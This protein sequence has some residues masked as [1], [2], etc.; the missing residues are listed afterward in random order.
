VSSIRVLDGSIYYYDLAGV[1][2]VAEGDTKGAGA[3][4]LLAGAFWLYVNDSEVAT[5][6][7]H[8]GDS[9]GDVVLFQA[10][11]GSPVRQPAT[12][13]SV[14]G[15]YRYAG[16]QSKLFGSTS[17]RP[18]SY[19]SHDIATGQEQN[20]E[21]QLQVPDD[22]DLLATA[23]AL[24]VNS[25]GYEATDKTDLYRIDTRGGDPVAIDTGI[26]VRF[27]TVGVD[28]KHLYLFVRDE[29]GVGTYGPALYAV[30]VAGGRAVAVPLRV[31]DLINSVLLP[32]DAGMFLYQYDGIDN[33]LYRLDTSTD[34]AA[35]LGQPLELDCRLGV[36]WS[37]ADSFY[38]TIDDI[39]STDGTWLM[40]MPLSRLP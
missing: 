7:Q 16:K 13:V 12:N 22:G 38:V 14:M 15:N 27:R 2:K 19:Y 20:I 17:F 25:S 30:P 37:T 18:F 5:F 6:A 31:R 35:S 36:A 8:D 32:T 34:A 24:Y 11:A 39:G 10:S 33:K 9:S 23:D 29:D 1:S 26:P 40:K 4:T 21:T 3:Q 28:A